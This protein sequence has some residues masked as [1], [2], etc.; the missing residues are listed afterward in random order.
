MTPIVS[1]KNNKSSRCAV[2]VLV[3]IKLVH[4]VKRCIE[5]KET[6]EE[7]LELDK[8]KRHTGFCPPS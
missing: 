3:A 6:Y 7:E 2:R 5:S 4:S 1:T 8:R